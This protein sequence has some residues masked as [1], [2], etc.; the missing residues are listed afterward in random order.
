[1]DMARAPENPAALH[2]LESL[3][4]RASILARFSTGDVIT[5]AALLFYE[6]ELCQE[7]KSGLEVCSKR[8]NP[9]IAAVVFYNTSVVAPAHV[10]PKQGLASSGKKRVRLTCI[11]S[12]ARVK[13]DR[14]GTRTPNLMLRRHTPYPLGHTTR[15]CQT[16]ASCLKKSLDAA[17]C[18]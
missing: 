3:I 10:R 14:E 1:M 7:K 12:I 4:P 13:S 11:E 2:T 9:G 15:R 5:A 6:H 8:P 16:V 18:D 17:T